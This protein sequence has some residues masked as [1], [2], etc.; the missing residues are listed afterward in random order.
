[1]VVLVLAVIWTIV[2]R[3]PTTANKVGVQ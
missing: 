1:M 2:S 3:S